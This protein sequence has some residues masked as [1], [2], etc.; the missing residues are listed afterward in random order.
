MYQKAALYCEE[1]R[2]WKNSV[3]YFVKML[4]KGRGPAPTLNSVLRI[5]GYFTII[6]RIYLTSKHVKETFMIGL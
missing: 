2:T 5:A 4:N 3:T 6:I 1:K